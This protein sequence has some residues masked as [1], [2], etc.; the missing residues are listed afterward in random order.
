MAKT[1]TNLY[2]TERVVDALDDAAEANGVSRSH[3]V[4]ETVLIR[5]VQEGYIDIP[6]EEAME[7][8]G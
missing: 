1:R 5:L 8:G 3:Y 2:V 7:G 6:F 4:R